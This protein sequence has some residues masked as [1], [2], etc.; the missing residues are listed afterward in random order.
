MIFLLLLAPLMVNTG[1][2]SE[3]NAVR[4][5]RMSRCCGCIRGQHEHH[6]RGYRCGIFQRQG[7]AREKGEE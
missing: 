3:N 4:Y 2:L 1:N 5:V 6:V 7:G